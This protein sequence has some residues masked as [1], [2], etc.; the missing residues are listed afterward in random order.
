MASNSE[1]TST[2]GVQ[3]LRELETSIL[4]ALCLTI[5]TAGSELK[6]KIL[7]S[8]SDDDFYFPV[9]KAVFR[10]LS[11]MHLRGD[12][13]ISANLE[14]ELQQAGVEPSAEFSME[15]LF[16]GSLPALSELSQWVVRLK[17][18]SRTGMIPTV[19]PPKSD[20]GTKGKA[21]ST[22]N[23]HA[24]VVR[25]VAEVKQRIAEEARKSSPAVTSK[26]KL[27]QSSPALVTP[28]PTP[29]PSSPPRSK[30]SLTPKPTPPKEATPAPAATPPPQAKRAQKAVLAS[31][32]E[33]WTS[34]ID[35]LASK[36]GR[37]FDTGFAH[38]D[39]KL[40]GLSPGLMLLVDE[41]KSR[42]FSFLKQL[43]D[44]FTGNSPMRCLY[45]AS[46][47]PK[48]ALRLKTL[49][50]LAAVPTQDIE[51]GRLK[52]DSPEWKRIDAEGRRAAEWLKKVF[53]YEVEGEIEAGLIRDL[54]KKLLEAAGDS[55]CLVVVDALEC[56]S[57]RGGTAS[58]V[59]SQLKSIADSMEVLIL[60]AT[61]DPTLLGCRDADYAAVFR[62]NKDGSVELEVLQSGRESSTI[63][64]FH[65]EADICRFTES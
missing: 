12:Y 63:V 17:E 52:K 19:E 43:T 4:K 5:N 42:L 34:Y 10:T 41:N 46:Q 25:S 40:G 15:V 9:T 45:V 29:P 8:L 61:S 33:D 37:T 54:T 6:Y 53:V 49:A 24:T 62:E 64:S 55:T 36:Q 11:E 28:R 35:E 27:S 60:A 56:I 23:G 30:P 3:E 16:G 13:V 20:P 44:Q 18:R 58:S 7:D 21:D 39:E 65:Y 2:I 50:R 57:R 59:A 38:L 48:A 51:K 14:E 22:P 31:E 32:G 26:P 47:L 1:P